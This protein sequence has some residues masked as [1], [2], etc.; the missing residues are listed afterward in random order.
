VRALQQ[1]LPLPPADDWRI[2]ERT[3]EVGRRGIADARARLDALR[4]PT[5]GAQG[6]SRARATH[7]RSPSGRAA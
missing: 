6:P 5:D 1:R 4:Q 2:D 3:R 7:R